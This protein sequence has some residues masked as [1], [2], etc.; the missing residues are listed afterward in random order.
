MAE[1]NES[2]NVPPGVVPV[3]Q[4]RAVKHGMREEEVLQLVGEPTYRQ[5]ENEVTPPLTALQQ[6][7][8]HIFDGAFGDD[9]DSLWVYAHDRRGR[10]KLEKLVLSFLGFKN[11]ELVASW[12]ETRHKPAASETPAPAR[13]L[14]HRQ[15][16]V[17]ELF[18]NLVST[19]SRL[20]VTSDPASQ[21]SPNAIAALQ[22]FFAAMNQWEIDSW[23]RSRQVKDGQLSREEET[24]VTAQ[25]LEEIFAQHCAA[26][27]LTRGISFQKPPEYDPEAER[28][29][30]VEEKSKAR[31]TIVTQ[32]MTGFK[33]K[34]KY[35]VVLT[36]G[37]WRVAKKAWQDASGKWVKTCL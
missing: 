5:T 18:A 19:K 27:S 8:I 23:R 7:G 36:D 13:P 4:M 9:Y 1:Q 15:A 34:C 29:V 20:S 6:L 17:P 33:K 32:Q 14:E 25:R 28:I 12:Q 16:K 10:F 26:G 31:V 21:A 22:G 37:A 11:G 3:E 35:D 24:A 30:E 2:S